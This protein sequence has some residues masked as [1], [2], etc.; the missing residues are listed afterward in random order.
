MNID[1]GDQNEA[2]ISESGSTNRELACS[3]PQQRT[4]DFEHGFIG[5]VLE[6]QVQNGPGK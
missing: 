5:L 3:D 1:W 4:V 2:Y 6:C